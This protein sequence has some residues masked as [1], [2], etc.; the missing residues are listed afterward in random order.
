MIYALLY[1][2]CEAWNAFVLHWLE[3]TQERMEVFR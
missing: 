3:N 1:L 2:W